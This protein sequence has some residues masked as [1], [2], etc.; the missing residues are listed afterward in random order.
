LAQTWTYQWMQEAKGIS[1]NITG[2]G[3]DDVLRDEVLKT[4]IRDI[5]NKAQ[6]LLLWSTLCCLFSYLVLI[7]VIARIYLSFKGQHPVLLTLALLFM[8]I[9]IGILIFATWRGMASNRGSFYIAAKSQIRYQIN[10]LSGQRKLITYYLLEYSALIGVSCC[11]FLSGI[12][13]GL[14]LLIRLTAP[15]SIMTYVLGFYFINSFTKQIEKLQTME[16]QTEQ[17]F[18]DKLSRN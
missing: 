7:V 2:Q 3:K 13:H 14:L 16:K 15:V 17:L 12:Q 11:F 1:G 6:K 5:D 9:A 18:L 10:K 8:Y 4:R